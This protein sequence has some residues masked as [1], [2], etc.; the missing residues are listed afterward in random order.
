MEGRED[1]TALAL[2]WY[3]RAGWAIGLGTRSCR[4][5]GN[6]PCLWRHDKRE[7][8]VTWMLLSTEIASVGWGSVPFG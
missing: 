8:F 3:C 7:V 2:L 4:W 1:S 6:N 5:T